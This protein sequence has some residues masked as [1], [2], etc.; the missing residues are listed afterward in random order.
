ME[1]I[2]LIFKEVYSGKVVSGLDF[3][4]LFSFEFLE[5]FYTSSCLFYFT[6][7][8]IVFFCAVS[9]IKSSATRYEEDS[10]KKFLGDIETAICLLI[11]FFSSSFALTTLAESYT[12]YQQKYF[13]QNFL[14]KLDEHQLD[15]LEAQLGQ[16]DSKTAKRLE[17]HSERL[18]EKTVEEILELKLP[19][20]KDKRNIEFH[21]TVKLLVQ[22]RKENKEDKKN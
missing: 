10:S 15:Y 19:L 4:A 9:C 6:A 12:S 3:N 18:V 21:D 1:E 20:N 5:H 2:Y 17:K 22:Y 8:I 13:E 7:S 16:L 14:S 11:C